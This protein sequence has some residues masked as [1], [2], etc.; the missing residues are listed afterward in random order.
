MILLVPLCLY[1]W[2]GQNGTVPFCPCHFVPY[3]FVLEPP[4]GP[5]IQR[6][7]PNHWNSTGYSRLTC[8]DRVQNH[9]EILIC[10]RISLLLKFVLVVHTN[11]SVALPVRET[12]SEESSLER[13]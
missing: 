3:H 8:T 10:R 13:T 11:R 12:Q 7:L 2:D 4:V 6:V 5:I 1:Q 9:N